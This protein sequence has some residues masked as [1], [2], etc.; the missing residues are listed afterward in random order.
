MQRLPKIEANRCLESCHRV[1]FAVSCP[2]LCWLCD[3]F[4][5]IAT[6]MPVWP[7]RDTLNPSN[8]YIYFLLTAYLTAKAVTTEPS[9]FLIRKKI[10]LNLL[11]FREL[12]Q[13]WKQEIKGAIFSD[14]FHFLKFKAIHFQTL[15]QLLLCPNHCPTYIINSCHFQTIPWGIFYYCSYFIDE[16]S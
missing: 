8:L 2:S 13:M 15:K 9:W 14:P 11:V 16:K 1:A 4:I 7:L 12:F 5:L 3:K 6:A 10:F